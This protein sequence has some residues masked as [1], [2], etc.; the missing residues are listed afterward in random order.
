MNENR[1]ELKEIRIKQLKIVRLDT[2]KEIFAELESIKD[3]Y[4]IE[5]L[6][7]LYGKKEQYQALKKKYGVD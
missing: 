5:L 7:E 2:A 6:N 3:E 1:K 4:G